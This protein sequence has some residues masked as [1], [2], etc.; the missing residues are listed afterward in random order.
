MPEELGDAP[1]EIVAV[2]VAPARER[3]AVAV[4]V[5]ETPPARERVAVTVAEGVATARVPEELGDAP[6]EIVAVG[7]TA[8]ARERVAVTVAV[9]PPR[10]AVAEAPAKGRHATCSRGSG[11]C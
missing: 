10:V 6:V 1:V 8:P 2:S 3:V 7:D 5:G 4:T 9:A 11:R